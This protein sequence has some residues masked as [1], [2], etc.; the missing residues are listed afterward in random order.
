MVASVVLQRLVQL[1]M[2]Y[3]VRDYTNILRALIPNYNFAEVSN[4]C[5]SNVT[6][7]E[8]DSCGYLYFMQSYKWLIT[9]I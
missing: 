7:L 5:D 2:L 6:C 9:F 4:K 1:L 8:F 3:A